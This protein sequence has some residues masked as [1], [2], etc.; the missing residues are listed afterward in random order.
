MHRATRRVPAEMLAIE[1]THLHPV[2]AAA[3]T[4]AWGVTRI[5]PDKTPMVSFEDA[6]YSVPHTLLGATVWV[7]SHGVGAGEQV[8]VVHDG[9]EGPVEVARHHRARPGSPR[10]AMQHFPP[11]PAGILDRT[12]TPRTDLEH[13][14]C[15]IGE[16]ARLWLCEAAAAGTVRI[17][18]KME[19]AVSLAKLLGTDR[20]DWALGHAAAFGRFAEGDL[21]AILDAHPAGGTTTTPPRR[22]DESRSLAQGTGGWAGLGTPT[23]PDT[24]TDTAR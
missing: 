1:R 7:R 18:V 14:F 8:I 13:G 2:P 10:S 23:D 20:V 22:A 6:Q 12:P 19:H 24:S 16:G 9:P 11:A 15:G 4:L 5:V 21:V 3:H 17:R